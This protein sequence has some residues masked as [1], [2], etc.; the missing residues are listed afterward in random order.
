MARCASDDCNRWRPELI[1]RHMRGVTI[2]G[3]WFCS[4][5]CVERMARTL[6][7]G[8][9]PRARGIPAVPPPRLG[10]LLRHRGAIDRAAL[11]AAV[12]AQKETGLRIG[13]Q[14]QAM[15]LVDSWTVLRVLATQG[16][17]SYLARV[18]AASVVKAP[19]G[20]A[21][22]T[23]RALALVPFRQPENGQIKVACAAPVPHAAIQALERLTGWHV[24]PYLVSDETWAA[25]MD[26]YG[27]EIPAGAPAAPRAGLVQTT[28]LAD[29]AVRIA[30]AALRARATRVSEAHW[31][32]YTWVRV[33]GAAGIHDVLLARA[34]SEETTCQADRTSL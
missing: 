1:A 32:P 16:G 6:L 11:E 8:I 17:V 2:D 20:L 26:A 5:G 23:V 28:S 34:N 15:G 25:L 24:Q 7:Q 30:E 4:Q 13:A 29:A 12:A 21:R 14:L 9:R 19:G 31:D 33:Q 22:E 10:V 18:D 27:S 3:R